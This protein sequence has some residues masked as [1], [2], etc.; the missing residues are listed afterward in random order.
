MSSQKP[1]ISIVTPV[2]NNWRYTLN[3]LKSIS[4]NTD[5]DYEVAVSHC[6]GSHST[7]TGDP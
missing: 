2:Y 3:C 1:E 4:E 6:G 7:V 5:G